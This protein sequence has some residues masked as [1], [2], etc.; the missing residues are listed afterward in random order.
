M[1]HLCL[2]TDHWTIL[3]VRY[4]FGGF[5]D[6]DDLK[7]TKKN[8]C[9]QYVWDSL[10]LVHELRTLPQWSISCHL[11]TARLAEQDN[12]TV[13][14]ISTNSDPIQPTTVQRK[15]GDGTSSSICCPASIS[16]YNKFM[17]GVD[18]NDRLR[19]YNSI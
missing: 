6:H 1:Y 11:G 8:Q 10:L 17:G 7:S 13:V 3:T 4:R 19:Q 12:R 2:T 5:L 9:K 15:T 16:L 14:V 18:F